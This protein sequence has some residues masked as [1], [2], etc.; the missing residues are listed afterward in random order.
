M[1]INFKY[2]YF[3]L[4]PLF[5]IV[6]WALFIIVSSELCS[7]FYGYKLTLY[8]QEISFLFGKEHKVKY[9]YKSGEL[10][11]IYYV[12]K[13]MLSNIAVIEAMNYYDVLSNKIIISSVD[14][15]KVSQNKTYTTIANINPFPLVQQA[16]NP[17]ESN[18]LK[19][20]FQ[21]PFTIESRIK[22]SHYCY[23]K[24]NFSSVIFGNTQNCS[25]VSFTRK[26]GNEILILKHNGKLYFVIQ[27][28]VNNSLLEMVNPMLL[29]K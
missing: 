7:F 1:K 17:R 14:K 12:N 20:T 23:I 10:G 26:K 25:I 29:Q 2:K 27:T 9:A 22:T 3:F 11:S 13:D 21:T 28:V 8:N 4:V 24:G 15:A 6:G 5:F 16:L 19:I 18:Y